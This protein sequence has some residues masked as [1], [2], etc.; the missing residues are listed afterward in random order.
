M[1]VVAKTLTNW[2]RYVSKRGDVRIEQ[3]QVK[4]DAW[5]IA[6]LADVLSKKLVMNENLFCVGG[7]G[8]LEVGNTWSLMTEVWVI[9]L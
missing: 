1:S 2:Q 6:Q 4:T 9:G 8:D 5:P 3:K 7:R